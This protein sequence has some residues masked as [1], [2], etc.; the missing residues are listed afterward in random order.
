M[1]ETEF[2]VETQVAEMPSEEEALPMELHAM[3]VPQHSSLVGLAF[4][5][6][7]HELFDV[8]ASKIGEALDLQVELRPV[9]WADL[10]TSR[11]GG[12]S[13]QLRQPVA[14]TRARAA[15]RGFRCNADI[16]DA[17][18]DRAVAASAE[19]RS[20]LG[21]AVDRLGLSA[22][23]ARRALRVARTCADLAGEPRVGPTAMAEAL[24]YREPPRAHATS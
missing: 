2:D 19:A 9:P 23:A 15:E 6:V 13:A 10:E 1:S 12:A 3:P 24:G 22:R 20:L 18:L 11:D 8:T 4:G 14:E 17:E 7:V 16:A 5:E 21:R